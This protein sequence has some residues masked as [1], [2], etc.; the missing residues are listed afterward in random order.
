MERNVLFPI[1]IAISI[2][3][4]AQLAPQQ[5]ATLFQH[6]VE[7]NA[8]WNTQQPELRSNGTM[9]SFQN[10][11]ERIAMHLHLVRE[12]L[13]EKADKGLTADQLKERGSLLQELD[14][15]ADQGRFPQNHVLPYRNPIFIDP[16]GT[17]CAVGQLMIAS[18]AG[19]LAVKIDTEMETAYIRDMHYA[20][21]DVWANK[22]GFTSNELAWIQPGYAP[23]IPWV[24]LGGGTDGQQVDE[25]LRLS[26]GDLVVAGQFS[27]AGSTVAQNVARWN[28]TA[29]EVMGVIPEGQVNASIEFD[30]EIYLG[31][32]F[33]AG[34]VDL[35]KW[36]NGTWE[37][38]SVFSSK[39]AEL[40][41]LHEHDGALY[42]AGSR[43]G[44]AGIDHGVQ[45][46]DNGTWDPVGQL[47][48]GPIEALESFDG[49]LIAGGQFT[50]I[51]LSQD[52]S[53]QHVARLNEN[54]WEQLGEG[55]NGSVYD[56]LV[57]DDELY[58]GGDLVGEVA[59]YFGLASFSGDALP[60][61]ALLP[62]LSNYFGS[63]LGGLAHINAM[64]EHD[65]RIFLGGEFFV[66]NG[67]TIGNNLA[68]FN[69]EADDVEPYA[70]FSGPVYDLELL[71]NNQLVACGVIDDLGN[72]ATTDLTTGIAVEDLPQLGV[73][74]NPTTDFV[75][76]T[77]PSTVSANSPLRI[78]DASGRSVSAPLHRIGN[79]L[80][81]DAHALS[82]GTY[83]IE[84]IEEASIVK[85]RF[86]KL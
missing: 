68:V 69:G 27:Y 72:I 58:A 3:A 25:L 28:G 22:N 2:A 57:S 38:S 81:I 14:R 84:V 34:T 52:N 40:T 60:W 33:I 19:D 1:S 47:L 79:T 82:S 55:L 85:G 59:T 44:F 39:Y 54:T 20:E 6:M 63:N 78:T 64:L 65:G 10:E 83:S 61:V 18:G 8:E 51:F 70:A 75:T 15:Y 73:Y 35:L 17:A 76:V 50:D 62:N 16:N 29:Y 24:A 67:M 37:Q 74:P 7:V 71:A 23:P 56:L 11:A 30:G 4:N 26:N 86:T 32:S 46:L 21:I 49:T 77:L 45:R 36:N 53:I 5:P 66:F 42:A 9:I 31:G 41:A 48:N 13:T 12:H 80:R 43:S